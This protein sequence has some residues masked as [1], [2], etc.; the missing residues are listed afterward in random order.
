MIFLH[1]IPKFLNS[2]FLNPSLKAC[3]FYGPQI[4]YPLTRPVHLS[5]EFP[6]EAVIEHL[7]SYPGFR[8]GFSGTRPFSSLPEEFSKAFVS[9]GRSRSHGFQF[10]DSFFN[11][12]HFPFPKLVSSR[13][14]RFTRLRCSSIFKV[15]SKVALAA[16]TRLAAVASRSAITSARVSTASPQSC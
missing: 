9:T 7:P 16:V 14:K 11:C 15:R 13:S 8:G 1:H 10:F 4:L 3:C 2:K 5:I 12:R 6:I